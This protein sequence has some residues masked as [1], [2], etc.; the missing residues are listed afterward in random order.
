MWVIRWWQHFST[1]YVETEMSRY[2]PCLINVRVRSLWFADYSRFFQTVVNIFKVQRCWNL[3]S[4]FFPSITRMSSIFLFI[5]SQGHLRSRQTKDS[6]QSALGVMEWRNKCASRRNPFPFRSVRYHLRG[7]GRQKVEV[8]QTDRFMLMRL[9]FGL[10][11]LVPMQYLPVLRAIHFNIQLT[12]VLQCF[13]WI[14]V[15]PFIIYL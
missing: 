3:R 13:S 5:I 9:L 14:N 12:H 6:I 7:C 2:P 15:A 8:K 11:V 10:L 4:D 1:A